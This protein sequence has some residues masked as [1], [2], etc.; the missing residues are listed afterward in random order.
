[1]KSE[2]SLKLTSFFWDKYNPRGPAEQKNHW[3]KRPETIL[4]ILYAFLTFLMVFF[5][6][7]WRDEAQGFLI[8]RDLSLPELFHQLH[9]EV[10]FPLWYLFIFPFV[11]LGFPIFGVNLLH[12]LLACGLAWLILEKFPFRLLTRVVLLFSFPLFFEFSVVARNYTIGFLLLAI[13]LILWKDLW[14]RPFFMAIL[15]ALMLLC[16]PF[17]AGIVLGISLCIFLQ[18][19]KKG[20]LKKKEFIIP[21]IIVLSAVI[22]DFFLLFSFSFSCPLLIS[23]AVFSEKITYMQRLWNVFKALQELFGLYPGLIILLAFLTLYRLRRSKEGLIVFSTSCLV[24]FTA[25]ILGKFGEMRHGAFFPAGAIAAFVIASGSLPPPEKEKIWGKIL[26]GSFFL[27][28][29]WS[30]GILTERSIRAFKSEILYDFSHGESTAQFINQN[31]PESTVFYV[32]PSYFTSIIAHLNHKKTFCLSMRKYSTFSPWKELFETDMAKTP[33]LVLANLPPGEDHG[34]YLGT[35]HSLPNHKAE[36]VFLLYASLNERAGIWARIEES[37]W[38]LL[39]ARPEK[40]HLYKDKYPL[41]EPSDF[42]L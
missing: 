21:V 40:V 18:A 6:E 22:I 28:V 29:I 9:C 42:K 30:S 13:F 20:L 15:L 34:L 11:K 5:H 41:F 24:I 2:K 7:A 3:L 37:Y 35:V 8:V 26:S 19:R 38:V 10:H 16:D 27:L 17:F 25:F 4:F 31:A 23:S 1:M 12:W 32:D 33:E 39:V 36:N 14:K